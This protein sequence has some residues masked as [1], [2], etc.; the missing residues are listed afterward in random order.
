MA[1]VN[2]I[3]LANPIDFTHPLAQGLVGCWITPS[4]LAGG[5]RLIDLSPYKNHGTRN[6]PTWAITQRGYGLDFTSPNGQ[7]VDIGT[8][9]AYALS[10]RK[11]WSA[12]FYTN[13]DTGD[14]QSI[15]AYTAQ[16]IVGL[17]KGTT[18][19]PNIYTFG[20]NTTDTAGNFSFIADQWNFVSFSWVS[21][22]SWWIYLNGRLFK[23]GSTTDTS[24]SSSLVVGTENTTDNGNSYDGLIAHPMVHA[25]GLSLSEHKDLYHA[26]LT[27]DYPFLNSGYDPA[28]LAA[29]TAGAAGLSIPVAMHHYRNLRT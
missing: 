4:A 23:E 29:A 18:F 1:Y 27:G 15:F 2:D 19:E 24:S 8:R 17:G 16:F 25:R 6:G 14:H 3:D 10:S 28:V 20:D 26:G 7:Y 9:D 22:G 12:W 13:G 5:R 11:T 21:G